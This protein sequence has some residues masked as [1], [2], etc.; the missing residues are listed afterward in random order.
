MNEKASANTALYKADLH[1][2]ALQTADL[3]REG[4]IEEV[5]TEILWD[6]INSMAG[7]DERELYSRLT[8]LSHH[9]LKYRYQ[10]QYRSRSWRSTIATQRRELRRVL[11]R[12]PGLKP[13][14]KVAFLE[15][16]PDARLDA[17]DETGLNPR[18][19]P[20]EP[21]FTFEQVLFEDYLP[22]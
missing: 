6:E 16:Y 13:E 21:P 11:R 22:D 7:R 19:I 17:L 2:W 8:V 15:T 12:S 3:V 20:V 1:E 4:R 18:D 5:D 9:L 14:A 10:P